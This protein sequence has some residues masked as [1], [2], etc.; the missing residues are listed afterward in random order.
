MIKEIIL[1]VIQGVTE[2]LPVS[3]SGHLALV[4]NLFGEANLFFFVALHV[5]SLLAVLIYFRKDIWKLRKISE[6]KIR[7]YWS[8]ILIG[9]IPAGAFGFFFGDLIEQAISS[10]LF[11]GIAFLITGSLLLATKFIRGKKGLTFWKS[12]WV[13]MA[14]ILAL[15]PGIS[16][17][18]TTTAVAMFQRV[19][20]EKA[21]RFSFIIFIPLA[22]GAMI[23]EFGSFYFD[24]SLLISFI[25]CFFV[26]LGALNLFFRSLKKNYFWIFGI[27]CFILGILS[28]IF[29]TLF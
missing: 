6:K 20:P 23:F 5:A 26:S 19:D 15:F 18:G 7:H 24:I 27:Y 13:G 22:I 21:G 10:Y 11:I 17:S 1:A 9:I 28:L 4:S 16:R 25:V 3:S 29:A 2:F 14:Q 12:F 8:Y